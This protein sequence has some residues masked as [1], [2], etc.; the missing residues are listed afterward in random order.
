MGVE[1]CLLKAKECLFWPGISKDI[2]EMSSNCA[3][4]IQYAKQQQ[5]QP[6]QQ[7]NLPSYPWQKLGSDLFD[8]KGSQYLLL[9]DYYSKFPVV[10][11]LNT[12]TSTAVIDHLKSI[13]AEYGIPETLVTD[14]GPQYHSKEFQT[15]CSTWGIEHTTSSPLFPQSN[16]FSER[17]VQTVKTLLKKA[18]A[19]GQDHYLGMLMYRTTPIDSKLPAPASLLNHRAYCTQI[20]TSGRLQRTQT[21][22]TDAEQLQHRQQVQK[23]QHDGKSTREL[24]DLRPG[25]T[26]A[27][28]NPHS[29]VWSPAEVTKECNEPRSY[30]VKTPSGSELR[31]NRV[32]LKPCAQPDQ[33]CKIV[34]DGDGQ[35]GKDSYSHVTRAYKDSREFKL[36]KI[37]D[38]DVNRKCK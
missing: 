20:P 29:R 10:R 13:F 4:C 30:V 18:D 25:H 19:S 7:H 22:D 31:R 23:L 12:T 37:Y 38:G 14:N 21:S 11:K 9:A 5:A 28:Y 1:K 26:V 32:Q 24:Q 15:F 27:M 17:M 2:K 35:L 3:T 8:Y 33:Q 6:L 34:Y 36:C 16:G